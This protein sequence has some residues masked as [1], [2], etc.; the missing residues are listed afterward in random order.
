[1][2]QRITLFLSLMCLCM[3]SVSAQNWDRNEQDPRATEIWEPRVEKVTPGEGTSAPSDAVILFDGSSFD[4]WQHADGSDVKWELADGAMTVVGGTSG[5]Q[6]KMG[7]GSM[8]LHIEWKSP[9]ELVS[10]GQGRGNSGVFLM[11]TYEVQV[12]DSYSSD[13]YSNGQAGS[14][15]KQNPPL[16]NACVETGEWNAY[17][18]IF[19]API[20]GE[21]GQLLRPAT[22]TV[23]HNGV[24]VQNHFTLVG[25]TEYKGFPQYREHADRLPI[26]LQDHG[27]PVSFRNIWVREL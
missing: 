25:P 15:Y 3:V 5:I 22:I 27:N 7:F 12:L 4:D 24:V 18:I 26:A 16:V 10:E 21:D 6:T 23:L 2:T 1:M 17:D 11:G 20:F 13:T 19:M 8:Q 9:E 14:V